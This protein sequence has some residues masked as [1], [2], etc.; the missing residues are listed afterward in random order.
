MK[1]DPGSNCTIADGI[2]AL[3]RSGD[4]YY[5]DPVIDHALAPSA[6]FNVSCGTWASS[7][8]ATLQWS[9]SSGSG[10]TDEADDTLGNT[11]S[12]TFTGADEGVIKVPNPRGRYSRVKIVIGGT[13]VFGVT[14]ISGKLRT[15]DQG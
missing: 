9:D 11:V 7:F 2:V 14:N 5:T 15:V 10:F 1:N 13:C 8:V 3:S 4:T 12:V 6:A